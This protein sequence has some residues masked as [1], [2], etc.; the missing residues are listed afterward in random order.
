MRTKADLS[1]HRVRTGLAQGAL[2]NRVQLGSQERQRP[3]QLL[4]TIA[5]LTYEYNN[6]GH[7]HGH[8][9]SEVVGRFLGVTLM[10]EP[11][12]QRSLHCTSV[13]MCK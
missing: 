13:V 5:H 6:E 3:L 11:P 2:D 10:S 9:S 8:S 7:N 1:V 4:T 12:A